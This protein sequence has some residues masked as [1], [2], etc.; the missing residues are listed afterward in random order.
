MP[1]CCKSYVVVQIQLAAEIQLGNVALRFALSE[2]QFAIVMQ[3]RINYK[4][5]IFFSADSNLRRIGWKF[6]GPKI[7]QMLFYKDI[8]VG[9]LTQQAVF[10]DLCNLNAVLA[11]LQCFKFVH[12]VGIAMISSREYFVCQKSDLFE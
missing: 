3:S 2:R 11:K 6:P 10:F 12:V 9:D 8:L 4:A 5:N 1:H 7:I